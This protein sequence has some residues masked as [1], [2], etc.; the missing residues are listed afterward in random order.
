MNKKSILLLLVMMVVLTGCA[1]QPVVDRLTRSEV[2]PPP[3]EGITD[4]TLAV[5]PL[6]GQQE[7][8]LTLH[9]HVVRFFRRF[10]PMDHESL[11]MGQSVLGEDQLFGETTARQMRSLGVQWLLTGR[12]Q[13]PPRGFFTLEVINVG[14]RYPFW[15]FGIPWTGTEQGTDVAERALQRFVEKMGLQGRRVVFPVLGP[16][17]FQLPALTKVAHVEAEVPFEALWI[18]EPAQV[19]HVVPESPVEAVWIVESVVTPIETPVESVWELEPMPHPEGPVV[20]STAQFPEPQPGVRQD[21]LVESTVAARELIQDP[22]AVQGV[23][24]LKERYV[25]Q[26][27]VFLE[28]E[29]ALALIQQLRQRG[30]EP[31]MTEL[32]GTQDRPTMWRVW[33]GLYD[34]Y[35]EAREHAREFLIKESLPIHVALQTGSVTMFRY[36]V[37]VA[38]FMARTRARLLAEVL[39]QKGYGATVQESRDATDRVWYSVWIGRYWN[40]SQARSWAKTFRDKE[41]MAVYVTPIDAYSSIRMLDEA[42]MAIPEPAPVAV[43]QTGKTPHEAVAEPEKKDRH[44]FRY[45]VQVGSFT[46]EQRARDLAEQLRAKGYQSRIFSQTDGQGRLWRMV[47]IGRFH[48]FSKARRLRDNYRSRE[49]RQA[50]ITSV[51]GL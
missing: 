39:R 35:L 5:L 49:G 45:A 9:R 27:G 51:T 20:S 1:L 8:A 33:V 34:G 28:V 4:G 46:E 38:S 10:V 25:L 23:D 21:A 13:Q 16:D 24:G 11:W 40:L 17:G 32:R 36:A 15:M 48:G 18:V 30:Y 2:E 19:V 44:S 14:D 12:Y 47:W 7:Q 26:A 50:F 3:K 42:V 22:V 31:E 41:G 29:H 37:Q 43:P 6:R